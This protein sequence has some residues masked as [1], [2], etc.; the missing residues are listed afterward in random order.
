MSVQGKR[1]TYD[2][3]PLKPA[4]GAVKAIGRGKANLVPQRGGDGFAIASTFRF[5][6]YA[7]GIENQLSWRDFQK[8]PATSLEILENVYS[9]AM[10]REEQPSYFLY[11]TAESASSS[12]LSP[13]AGIG[14]LMHEKGHDIYDMSGKIALPKSADRVLGKTL[15]RFMKKG[16]KPKN[17]HRWCNLTADM[18]LERWL[19]KEYPH[20]SVRLQAVQAWIYELEKDVRADQSQFAS[21]V[22]MYLRDVG[23]GHYNDDYR[24]TINEYCPKARKLVD[25]LSYLWKQL[26]PREGDTVEDTV[27]LPLLIA[28]SL[29]EAI[30]DGKKDKPQDP[31]QDPPVDPQDPPQDPSPKDID[32]LLGGGGQALD[33]STAYEKDKRQERKEVD[34]QIYVTSGEKFV[35][36]KLF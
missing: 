25:S 28:L 16:Y 23:K 36:K 5:L 29:M 11:P 15:D 6:S 2:F 14:G 12:S 35:R 9:L 33:P 13:S 20:T 8:S 19:V 17:L 7:S 26:I 27:H 34:H 18:R 32:D 3:D 1:H 22:M 31:P 4:E 21:H 10:M 24:K 30:E